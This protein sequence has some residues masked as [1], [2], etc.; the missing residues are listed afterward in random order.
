MFRYGNN[1]RKLSALHNVPCSAEGFKHSEDWEIFVC[2]H[3]DSGKYCR[4]KWA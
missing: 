2:V 3:C 4:W 1:P